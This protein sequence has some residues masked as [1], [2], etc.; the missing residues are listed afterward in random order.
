MT[1]KIPYWLGVAAL[2]LSLASPAFA[3]D[4]SFGDEPANSAAPAASA[5][6]SPTVT[7][8]QSTAPIGE[9]DDPYTFNALRHITLKSLAVNADANQPEHVKDPLMPINRKVFQFNQ[10]MDK[11]LLLPVARTYKRVLPQPVRTSVG[12]FFSN[13]REPWNAVNHL[14]Q[15]NPKSSAKSLERFTVNTLTSL[16]LA[17]PASKWGIVSTSEDF[18][19]TLGVWGVKSGPFLML[20]F[21]GPST[22]RDASSMVVDMYARPQHYIDNNSVQWS[23]NGLQVV[24]LRAGL[25][26]VEDL[27]QGDQYTLLRDLYLQRRQF[28]IYG[29]SNPS[30]SIDD[31]FG[32][33]G[34]G[35]TSP[36]EAAPQQQSDSTVPTDT[37]IATGNTAGVTAAPMPASNSGLNTQQLKTVII[38]STLVVYGYPA[39]ITTISLA[40]DAASATDNTAGDAGITS[41]TATIQAGSVANGSSF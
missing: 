9:N 26:G 19:Q 23:L 36:P 24:N 7:D 4:E 18:G 8:A 16:G 40:D 30:A 39:T 5:P 13:L 20:P 6:A 3:L 29:E 15:G 14:L 38:K 41:G 32:D 17:D 12:N 31:S 10:T 28:A 2:Q 21:L 22:L 27:V 37:T 34:D 1:D 25:I 11:Y 35:S 33:D